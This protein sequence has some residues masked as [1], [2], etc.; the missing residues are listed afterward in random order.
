M[1]LYNMSYGSQ[2]Y[3]LCP[4]LYWIIMV[5]N[6]ERNYEVVPTFIFEGLEDIN[7][8]STSCS[9]SFEKSSF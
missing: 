9:S 8:F 2:M 7:P 3:G 1:Y 5:Q 6:P 4:E